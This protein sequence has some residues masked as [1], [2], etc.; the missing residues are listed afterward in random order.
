VAWSRGLP[1]G[2]VGLLVCL[3]FA[4]SGS[5][6]LIYEVTWRHIFT[7]VFGST[8]YAV[9]V[10]ISVFMGGLALGSFVF[11]KAADRARRHL[12]FCAALEGGIAASALLVLYALGRAEGLYALVFRATESPPLLTVVQ[13]L[14]SALILLGP[15]FLMGGTLPVLSRFM[16]TRRGKVGPAVGILYGVNTLGAAAGAFLTG[17]VLIRHFGIRRTIYLAASVNGALAVAFVLLH[18]AWSAGREEKA[19]PEVEPIEGTPL[20]TARLRLL[21]TALGVSGFASFSYEVLWTRLLTFQ[22]ETTV[23]AFSAMLTTFLLGLGLGG[24]IVGL[25]KRTRAK[26]HY[27]R[28]FGLLEA[29]VGVFGLGTILLFTSSRHGYGS[30]ANRVLNQ[31]GT[32]ALIMLVPT[33]LMGAAFPIACHLYATGVCETGRSVGRAYVFNTLGCIA[34]GLLTGFVLVRTLGTQGSLTLA[35]FLMVAMGSVVLAARPGRT[36]ARWPEARRYGPTAAVWVAALVIASRTPAGFLREYFLRNQSIAAG[37]PRSSIRLLGYSEGVEGVVIACESDD[38]DRT[39]AA[40]SLDVAG[41]SYILRNTQ[42]LQAHVPML[43]HPKP[44][45]VCQIGFGS[46]ETAGIFATYDVDRFDCI[47]ISRAMIDV[48]AKHFADINRGS[49]SDPRVHLIVMDATTYLKYTTRLYDVIANDATWPAQAG[50]S[51]LYTREHFQ[52]GC[53]HLKPGGMMTSWVPFDMPIEDTK[54]ILKTFHTVF[55]HVYIWSTPSRANKHSLIIGTNE[56]LQVDAARFLERFNRFARADLAPV[57]LDDPAVFLACHLAKL[58]G[59]EPSLAGVPLHTDDLPR[60]Q[61]LY[62]RPEEY[63]RYREP[64]QLS[65][66]R[67][68]FAAH[69]DSILSHLT[70][71]TALDAAEDLSARIHRVDEANDHFLRSYVLEWQDAARSAAEFAEG[72]RLAP[73]HPAFRSEAAGRLAAAALTPEQIVSKDLSSLKRL[74]G[75]LFVEGYYQKALI[76]LQEWSRREPGSAVPQAELGLLYINV[77][78]PDLAVPHLLRAAALD[79]SSADVQFNLGSAYLSTGRLASAIACFEEALR[80]EPDS[81][82]AVERLGVAYDIQGQPGKAFELLTRAVAL[83]PESARARKSMAVFLHNHGRPAE[84]LPHLEKL[85][86]LRPDSAEAHRLLADAYRKAGNAEGAEL[87]AKRA[88][89]LEASAQ[90]GAEPPANRLRSPTSPDRAP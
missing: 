68:L 69:R 83:A 79:P 47:E 40:G 63:S 1:A 61:F 76:A 71:V 36:G 33:T 44:K 48:A 4:V 52:N 18:F 35:S 16:A 49:A 13:V 50:P 38:G 90:R 6:G 30:F 25:L 55:P 54:T 2:L 88:A 84:A 80:L 27:W 60:L 85:A 56:P 59:E 28:I 29:G 21:M 62:A 41:T 8:T 70:N 81:A 31:F 7:T 75:Q 23:Y 66:A 46:G 57:Y 53:D 82:D 58:E 10:V 87:H 65:N 51:M 77:D 19:G 45:D 11:G 72:A 74:A 14:V 67:E 89:Q 42:K 17:F 37:K 15:T 5:V 24:A 9:S 34:G 20:G 32:S 86:E 73:Q 3:L 39:I 22:F 64:K 78:R 12:L 43:L 26:A